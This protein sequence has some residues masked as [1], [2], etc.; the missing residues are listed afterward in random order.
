M[1][2]AMAACQRRSL[3]E[4]S[5][6][7]TKALSFLTPYS[8]GHGTGGNEIRECSRWTNVN[9]QM[10]RLATQSSPH[11]KIVQRIQWAAMTDLNFIT[12]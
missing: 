10:K 8:Q 6:R 2:G 5:R 7:S 9:Q 1:P 11:L 12:H 3:G 4:G